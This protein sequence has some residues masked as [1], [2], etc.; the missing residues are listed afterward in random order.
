MAASQRWPHAKKPPWPGALP[1]SWVGEKGRLAGAGIVNGAEAPGVV[2][3]LLNLGVERCPPPMPPMPPSLSSC[4][5]RLGGGDRRGS[6]LY[7]A[8]RMAQ[9]SPNA[10]GRCARP[11]CAGPLTGDIRSR[12][13]Q[14]RCIKCTHA[15]SAQ[16]AQ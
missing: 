16:W 1:P 11:K 13:S 7:M 8:A 3:E 5:A 6:K 12:V 10:T 15:S 14:A 2:G 4:V 9:A